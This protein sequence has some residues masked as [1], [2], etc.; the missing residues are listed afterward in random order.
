MEDADQP[1]S[2]KPRQL[3][4]Q[5]QKVS[6]I[7]VTQQFQSKLVAPE[8]LAT[9]TPLRLGKIRSK[10]HVP[11]G[12]SV[13]TLTLFLK[14]MFA[15]IQV[16]EDIA[17]VK[18]EEGV[19]IKTEKGAEPAK[20]TTFSLQDKVTI[21]VGSTQGVAIVNWDAH[22]ENDVLADAV[23]ALIAQAQCSPAAIRLTSQ[24][25]RHRGGPD[26]P[27]AKPAVLTESR[28]HLIRDT[29]RNQFQSVEV[30]TEGNTA[31]FEIT[32]ETGP[33]DTTCNLRVTFP[34]NQGEQ[35]EL[36]AESTDPIFAKNVQDCVAGLAAATYPISIKQ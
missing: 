33:E 22:P 19:T 3:P 9:Y 29:L 21:T 35:A 36:H 10:L 11:F 4:V 14:E 20:I 1:A 27:P 24:P 31:T 5:G 13:V 2:K 34:D 28:I 15:G 18:T 6:G 30:V 16:S 8:D 17:T 12:G 23:V 32:S 7:L 26:A 25:C